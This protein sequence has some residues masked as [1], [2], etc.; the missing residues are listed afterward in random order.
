MGA[1]GELPST[2]PGSRSRAQVFRAGHRLVGARG[3]DVS[4]Q[5]A[6]VRLCWGL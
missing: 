5:D 3:R 2:P 1:L 6:A 4:R